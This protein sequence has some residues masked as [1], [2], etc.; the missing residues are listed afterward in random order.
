MDGTQSGDP[1]KAAEAIITALQTPEIPLHL[2]LGDD[3]FEAIADAQARR[4]RDLESWETLSRST[5]L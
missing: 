2:A 1:R 3:A 4:R 5:A